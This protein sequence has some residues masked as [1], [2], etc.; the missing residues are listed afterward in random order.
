[1]SSTVQTPACVYVPTTPDD[2]SKAIKTIGSQR[3]SFAVSSGKHA[4]NKGFSSTTGIQ[5]SMKGFQHVNLSADKSY[6]DIGSG[7]IWDNVYAALQGTGVNIV[8]GRVTG[9]GVG[10]FISGGGGFS[11]KTNQYGLTIDTLLQAD[12]VMP[13][14]SLKS[15][16]EQSDPDLFWALKGGGNRFGIVYNWRLK[17]NPQ[18]D[19]VYGGLRTYTFDQ[20]DGVV[21]AV[22]NFAVNNKDPKAQVL[23]TFNFVLGQ[24]G[25]SLLAFYDGPSAPAGVFD[26][27][28]TSK[29]GPK[30]F[31]D[32]WKAQSFGDLVRATPSNA[33]QYTRGQFMSVTFQNFSQSI[34]E[35]CVNQ[36][37]VIGAQSFLHGGS[38]VSYDVE[39]FLMTY[40]DNTN[41][42]G[43]WPHS[44]SPLPLNI[45]FAW[46]GEL[47]DDFWNEQIRETAKLLRAQAVAEG[48]NLDGLYLYPNYAVVDTPAS[49]LY[50]SENAA[51]LQ[52]LR[53][54]YDPQDVMGLTT[55][56]SFV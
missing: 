21:K 28:D 56:F 3:L 4:S 34:I 6:V 48:Q 8:G 23:P 45:Y 22:S 11:W 37:K 18:T 33:T 15:V 26:G 42:G 24:P 19:L 31:T 12:M 40:S 39:P 7:N 49:D 14:G 32:A 27:F 16:T 38:F 41:K 13:D 5:I 54:R 10:G 17:T 9:V 50:G 36:T 30:P 46:N 1:M 2:L 52:T 47:N 53:Q 55:F 35:Q 29:G 44:N 43:A 25:V 51:R 20:I